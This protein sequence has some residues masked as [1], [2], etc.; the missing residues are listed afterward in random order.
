MDVDVKLDSHTVTA[1]CHSY[2]NNKLL[3]RK[4]ASKRDQVASDLSKLRNEG[5]YNSRSSPNIIRLK[6]KF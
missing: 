6:I 5:V 3:R 4:C 2:I 1:M